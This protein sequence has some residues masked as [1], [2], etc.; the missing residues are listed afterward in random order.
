MTTRIAIGSQ[1]TQVAAGQ[2]GDTI[3]SAQIRIALAATLTNINLGVA[4]VA[5][6]VPVFVEMA[7][8]QATL[9]ALP[10]GRGGNMAQIAA[11]SGLT[12]MSF[13][14]VS[15]AAMSNFSAAVVPV[16]APVIAISLLGIPIQVNITGGA[17]IGSSG[18]TTLS[19]S[20][21]DIAAGTVKSVPAN[22][23]SAFSL[24]SSNLSLS[25]VILGNPGVLASL[26][27]S[28]LTTLLGALNPVVINLVA[29]LDTPVDALLATLGLQFGL[30]DVQVFDTNCRTPTLVG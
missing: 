29:Q 19:F 11:T 8:G 16:A 3:H 20:Q 23:T 7:G 6:Q 1:M 2:I 24:L 15:D 26:L 17:N 9:S 28:T 27:N 10:C 30:I 18:P 21:A 5:I 14:T 4:T 12:R 13:G 25:A 22:Y